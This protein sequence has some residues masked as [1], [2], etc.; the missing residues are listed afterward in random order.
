MEC[1]KCGKGLLENLFD[2][3]L[4]IQTHG[5]TYV[6]A[7][8]VAGEVWNTL[9]EGEDYAIEFRKNGGIT[10]SAHNIF[11]TK[12]PRSLSIMLALCNE[13]RK[14]DNETFK[15]KALGYTLGIYSNHFS[16]RLRSVEG[17]IY[18]R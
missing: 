2:F 18:E 12:Y 13:M 3:V 5:C 1:P 7:E 15:E 4:H 17:V 10:F 16:K 11:I 8:K 9:A 6:E 14:C